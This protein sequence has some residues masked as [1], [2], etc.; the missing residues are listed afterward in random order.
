[1]KILHVITSLA[2]GGAEKLMVDLLPRLKEKGHEVELLLFRKC[3]SHFYAPLEEAGIKIHHLSETSQNVYSPFNILR[4]RKF[5]GKYDVIHTHNTACQLFVPLARALSL[6][7]QTI[8]TT[9]HSTNNR[10]RSNKLFYYLDKWMYSKYSKIICVSNSVATNL[11]A[12]LPNIQ[13]PLTIH[14]GVEIS[15]YSQN[16]KSI[17]DKTKFTI[18]MVSPLR[19]EK[20]H[21]TLIRALALL[22]K[23][24]TLQL[25]GDGVC[26]NNLEQLVASLNLQNRVSFLGM[27]SDIP[28]ILHNSDF[29]VLSSHWEGLSLSSVEGMASGIP[30]IASNVDGLREVVQGAGILFEHGNSKQ[31]A[32]IILKL[33]QNPELYAETAKACQERAKQLDISFMV[34]N[35][36]KLYL[37]L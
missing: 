15:L 31:L 8:V 26:R 36:N 16:I 14:N 33:S 6:K 21:P 29:C 5:I 4:L 35:Y 34:E 37:S 23:N 11:M 17:N 27:R 28:E 3:E 24:F 13:H 22:P 30:F 7:K 25:A 9:E 10:R 20:D 2:I 19:I 18:S 12:Y 32:D 1:M